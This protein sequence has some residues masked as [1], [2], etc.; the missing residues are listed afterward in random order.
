MNIK[1]RLIEDIFYEIELDLDENPAER[2]AMTIDHE[3]ILGQ[4]L[5]RTGISPEKLKEIL[6]NGYL[7]NIKHE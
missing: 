2:H 6:V 3:E 4:F 5:D 7:Y 1:D